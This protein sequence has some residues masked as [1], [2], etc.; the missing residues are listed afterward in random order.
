MA[1]QFFV[2]INENE[3]EKCVFKIFEIEEEIKL[4]KEL[5][6]GIKIY[7]G[8][9]NFEDEKDGEIKIVEMFEKNNEKDKV[10][11][12]VGIIKPL[13]KDDEIFEENFVEEN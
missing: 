11:E 4:I 1:F 6:K 12:I 5:K 7:I 9:T 3:E 13:F 10:D 2:K 8:E